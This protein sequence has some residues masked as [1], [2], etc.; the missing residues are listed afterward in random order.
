[1]IIVKP[2]SFK[3][4]GGREGGEGYMMARN[5]WLQLVVC[6]HYISATNLQSQPCVN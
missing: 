4:K 2:V 5:R 6:L 3:G 1:M